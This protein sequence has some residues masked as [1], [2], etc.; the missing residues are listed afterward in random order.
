LGAR[1]ARWLRQRGFDVFEIGNADRADYRQT[2]I[3]QR[4]KRATAVQEVAGHLRDRLGIGVAIRQ[5]VRY[6]EADVLLILGHDFPDSLP[7]N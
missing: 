6:P 7:V 2:V 5:T 3:V 4:S 1:A